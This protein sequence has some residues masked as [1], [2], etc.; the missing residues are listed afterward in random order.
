[1]QTMEALQP[2]K[3]LVVDDNRMNRIKLVHLLE[4]EGH[5]VAAAQDGRAALAL[6]RAQPFDVVLLDL[7]MP[8]MDGFQTLEVIKGDAALRATIVIVISAL[9][10]MESVVRCIEM[11]AEDYLSKPFDPVLLRA[12][13]KNSL[14][15]KKIRDLEQAYLRQEMTLRQ[16]EKLATLGKLC[17]G[18]AH[19]LNNPA[20]AATRSAGH[21][22]GAIE[23]WQQAYQPLHQE[24]LSPTQEAAL[25]ELT[26]S[27]AERIA[28]PVPLDTLT[29]SDR[30]EEV[31][32]W[33]E[34]I[35]V[36]QGWEL[37]PDL[38]AMGYDRAQLQE[39]SA[40]FTADHAPAVIA[41]LTATYT[42]YS[43]AA[44]IGDAASRISEII[45]ALKSYTYMDQAPVQQIDLHK[46]LEDT[47]IMLRHK[48]KHGITVQ[49]DYAP[50]LPPIEAYGSA[51]NQV[52]TNLIDNA[53]TAMGE[54]G[55]LTLRTRRDG[56]WLAVTVADTGSGIPAELQAKIFD[57]FFTTK[58]PG[59]G[60]GLGLSIAHQIVT[61]QH[62]GQLTVRSHPGQ[63]C[64]EVRLPVR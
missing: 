32:S 9:D 14:E 5:T 28:T 53:I 50:D 6:L 7:L 61:Q 44:E 29:R 22:P 49:R 12:R 51:L 57:P 55:Q 15:K 59:E 16:N 10:E 41:W 8:E 34:M 2:G 11:G 63:T 24:G 36:E 40:A 4:S 19:E 45:G 46:G 30:E 31:E 52:W 18:V 17:A 54:H 39:L 48:L 43:L 23:R 42:L 38:V 26:R 64:F 62:H 13:L 58:P 56:D 35:G 27:V 37:A 25:Q 1:M 47:L 20:A 60:S 3:I 33:C 21:L